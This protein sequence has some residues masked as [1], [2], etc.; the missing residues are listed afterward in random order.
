MNYQSLCKYGEDWGQ[1]F[2][3]QDY[4]HI[5]G[6]DHVTA[7]SVR[8]VQSFDCSASPHPCQSTPGDGTTSI[9]NNKR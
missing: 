8:V 3:V 4:P 1:S 5:E 7:Q 9:E 6:C 2:T